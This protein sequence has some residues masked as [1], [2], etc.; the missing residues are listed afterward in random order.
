MINKILGGLT[1]S[2]FMVASANAAHTISIAGPDSIEPGDTFTIDL[3]GDFPG[4]FI[5]GGVQLNYDASLLTVDSFEFGAGLVGTPDPDLSCP[6]AAL[7]P[8]DAPGTFSIVWGQ[9]LSDLLPAGATDAVMATLTMSL[10]SSR[11]TPS[12]TSLTL[13]DFSTFA[14]GWFGSG[15]SDLGGPPAFNGLTIDIETAVIPLPAAAWLMIGG[16]GALF[17]FRRK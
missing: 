6:G 7:C 9:F 3:V 5:A 14:G 11:G 1:L 17:G 10:A 15:F 13:S 8:V 16:L 12:S 4:G 2:L